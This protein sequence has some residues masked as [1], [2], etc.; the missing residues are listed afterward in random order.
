MRQ[1]ANGHDTGVSAHSP[2]HPPVLHGSVAADSVWMLLSHDAGSGARVL[3]FG[4]LT[5]LSFAVAVLS[6]R[7]PRAWLPALLVGLILLL[8]AFSHLRSVGLRP[9]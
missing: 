4:A 5:S 6:F 3:G 8:L 7:W 2:S 1:L 9:V